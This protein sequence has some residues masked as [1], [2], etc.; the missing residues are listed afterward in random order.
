M[1]GTVALIF[2]VGKSRRRE[3][4]KRPDLMDPDELIA[5]ICVELPALNPGVVP[6]WVMLLPLGTT[7]TQDG[8]GPYTIRDEAHAREIIAASMANGRPLPFDYAHEIPIAMQQ[9]KSAPASGWMT[10]LKVS[11]GGIWARVDWTKRGAAS[12]ADKEYRYLSPWFLHAKD[13]T[14]LRILGAG[15]VNTP[16]LVQL[17]ALAGARRSTEPMNE[18]LRQLLELLNLPKD[19]TVEQ[20]IAA[21]KSALAASTSVTAIAA[22]LGLPATA[23]AKDIETALATAKA[24][25][26]KVAA[27]LG[28]AATATFDEIVKAVASKQPVDVAALNT[29]IATLN[30]QVATLNAKVVELQAGQAKGTAEAEVDAAIKAGKLVPALRDWGLTQATA[31]LAAFK[32]YVAKM[33]TVVNPGTDVPLGQ[34]TKNAEGL[35]E[36]EMAVAT[37]LGQTAADFKKTRDAEVK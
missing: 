28:L 37:A 29:H 27:A 13:G 11:D 17:P 25:R 30:G 10:E 20:A 31:N 6:E 2:G 7:P 4:R 3:T 21:V 36:T 15:L 12:I 14:V 5:A 1:A 35:T 19:T 9:G 22:S 8:R 26:E 16:N 34:P 32:D 33:P 23:A 24:G 18:L